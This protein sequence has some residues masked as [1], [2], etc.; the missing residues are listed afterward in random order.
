M[1][2]NPESWTHGSSAERRAWFNRGF[3]SGDWDDC[4]TFSS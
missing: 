1:D 2:V 4:D 3:E